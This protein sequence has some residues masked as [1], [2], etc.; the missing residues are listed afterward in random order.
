MPDLDDVMRDDPSRADALEAAADAAGPMTIPPE[1]IP[2]AVRECREEADRQRTAGDVME[3]DRL[4]AM[5][6]EHDP[7]QKV[8]PTD[9]T[10]RVQDSEGCWS[11]PGNSC[12]EPPALCPH[13]HG[14]MWFELQDSVQIGG[15]G[16]AERLLVCWGCQHFAPV[17]YFPY[18][19]RLTT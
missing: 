5:A 7:D 1:Y 2:A 13:C 12:R 10:G 8:A 19:G 15:C 4:D 18:P 6:D 17:A 14:A 9:H 16:F 11:C 3:A